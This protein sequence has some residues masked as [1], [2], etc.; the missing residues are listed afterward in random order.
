MENN[1]QQALQNQFME[2]K[3]SFDLM[4][5]VFKILSYWYLFVIGAAIALGM[6][7]LK[8]R[9]WIPQYVSSGTIIIQEYG[10]GSYG[11]QML[12]SGFGVQ[13]GYK[14]VNRFKL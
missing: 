9:K 3:S 2:E 5:W 1:Q 4:E 6:A 7:A 13:Q 14:N 12:M 10:G 8:N 11:S